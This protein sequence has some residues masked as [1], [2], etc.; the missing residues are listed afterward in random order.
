MIEAGVP[1]TRRMLQHAVRAIVPVPP[2][3]VMVAPIEVL[4]NAEEA[5]SEAKAALS[6]RGGLEQRGK[7]HT[8]YKGREALKHNSEPGHLG[9]CMAYRG[10]AMQEFSEVRAVASRNCLYQILAINGAVRGVVE[11]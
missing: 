5:Q 9:S 7:Q 10:G 6:N 2:G 4:R 11:G 8:H 1:S 3:V